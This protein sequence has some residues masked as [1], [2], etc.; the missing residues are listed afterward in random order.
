M[1]KFIKYRTRVEESV[2][3]SFLRQLSDG[4][5]FLNQK[6]IVHRDL[7]PANI[8]LSEN[9]DFAILK[10]ADFGF[11]KHLEEAALTQTQC[12]TPLYMVL[13]IVLHYFYSF[14]CY[15]L[16]IV[17]CSSSQAPEIFEMRDY[18]ATVDIW[19]VGGIFYEMLTGSVPYKGSNPRELYANIKSKPL[20][21]PLQLSLTKESVILLR[22]VST[23]YL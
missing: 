14:R 16:D 17:Y 3:Q 12:G 19:S 4:L 6:N 10:F 2:A 5:N 23:I 15:A 9:S 11:A 7:K 8:L 20:S 22:N 1:A 13:C 21:I 18:D